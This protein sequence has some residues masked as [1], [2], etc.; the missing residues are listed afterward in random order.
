[1]AQPSTLL[2]VIGTCAIIFCPNQEA[3][4][5]IMLIN[6]HHFMNLISRLRRGCI[7]LRPVRDVKWH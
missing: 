3:T 2:P 5:T 1:M 7:P 4:G 6:V